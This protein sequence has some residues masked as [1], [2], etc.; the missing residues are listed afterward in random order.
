MSDTA[1]QAARSSFPVFGVLGL[2]FIV[3]KTMG[4][5]MV[6]QWSWWLVLLPFYGPFL[7]ILGI[8]SI[9]FICAGLLLGLAAI[10]EA[11]TK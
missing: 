2:I 11:V 7:L 1:T 3:M 10:V 5:G 8:A 6:A 4:W 9:F